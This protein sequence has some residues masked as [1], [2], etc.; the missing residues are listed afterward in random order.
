MFRQR[1]DAISRCGLFL[2]SWLQR[3]AAER[4][5][6]SAPGIRRVINQIEVVPPLSPADEVDEEEIC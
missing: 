6:A 1:L 4:G 5:E 2:A 3:K